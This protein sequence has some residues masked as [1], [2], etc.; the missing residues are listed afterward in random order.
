[1][2]IQNDLIQLDILSNKSFVEEAND[3]MEEELQSQ[4]SSAVPLEYTPVSFPTEYLPLEIREEEPIFEY[5]I[6][7]PFGVFSPG[8]FHF[9]KRVKL[10]YSPVLGLIAYIYV[11][12]Q[13]EVIVL[14]LEKMENTRR[15][16][17]D[18][19]LYMLNEKVGENTVGDLLDEDKKLKEI[20]VK[21]IKN[22]VRES[23]RP[24][25]G[26]ICLFHY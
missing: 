16:T 13:K 7:Y 23:V 3:V 1:M 17:K 11:Y 10:T 25:I 5:S 18:L 9:L 6:E 22:H 14:A 12:N 24:P 8:G 4:Q 20:L 2:I 26:R 15:V 21:I 19:L